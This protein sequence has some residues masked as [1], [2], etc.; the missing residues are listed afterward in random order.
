MSGV[1]VWARDSLAE[2]LVKEVDVG[3]KEGKM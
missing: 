1:L 3:E 2:D